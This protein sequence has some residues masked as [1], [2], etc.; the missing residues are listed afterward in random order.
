MPSR[1]GVFNDMKGDER[2][3]SETPKRGGVK[4]YC[5]GLSVDIFLAAGDMHALGVSSP[6]G[7]K[8]MRE[9]VSDQRNTCLHV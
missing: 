4:E 2:L 9:E 7:Q 5:Q 6:W 8:P 1:F 3:L